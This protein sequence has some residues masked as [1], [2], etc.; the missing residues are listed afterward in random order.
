[1]AEQVGLSMQ[2][3][4]AMADL[5]VAIAV[6]VLEKDSYT[7]KPAILKL[8]AILDLIEKVYP[9]LDTAPARAAVD[10][11]ADRLASDE[12]NKSSGSK[13]ALPAEAAAP[14]PAP[15]DVPVTE[16]EAGDAQPSRPVTPAG[17]VVVL[18]DG[19]TASSS[20]RSVTAVPVTSAPAEESHVHTDSGQ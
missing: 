18:P 12:F 19:S 4:Q 9:A 7:R 14:K 8:A 3:R 1:A 13:P 17:E 11:L 15:A 5:P 10:K 2:L 16:A 6:D 20:H